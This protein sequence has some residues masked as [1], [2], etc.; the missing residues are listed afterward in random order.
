MLRKFKIFNINFCLGPR[1]DFLNFFLLQNFIFYQKFQQKLDFIH[2]MEWIALKYASLIFILPW[3]MLIKSSP[4]IYFFLESF[5]WFQL[6][7]EPHSCPR[8]RPATLSSLSNF[9][10]W[11]HVFRFIMSFFLYKT[12]QIL[13]FMNSILNSGMC[14]FQILTFNTYLE[15]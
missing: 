8:S 11:Y 5:I 10:T 14:H 12:K 2:W 1:N 6:P 9:K 4:I 13:Y 3:R 7:L 15:F